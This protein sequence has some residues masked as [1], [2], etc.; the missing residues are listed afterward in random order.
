MRLTT[1]VTAADPVTPDASF[2][3]PLLAIDK[4][5]RGLLGRNHAMIRDERDRNSECK[6]SRESVYRTNTLGE[7]FWG[8]FFLFF[9][10][11]LD[12]WLFFAS[13]K[14]YQ[15]SRTGEPVGRNEKAVKA[16]IRGID[17]R[18]VTSDRID[19]NQGKLQQS[20]GI[21]NEYPNAPNEVTET[22]FHL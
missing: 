21:L 7:I 3:S 17:V 19:R 4:H 20:R 5:C 11:W 16:R 12:G 1:V 8:V 22:P 2:T 6:M 14:V 13:L 10:F 18:S 15:V 9:F